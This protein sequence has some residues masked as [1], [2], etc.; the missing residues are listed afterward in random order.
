M[1]TLVTLYKF[2]ILGTTVPNGSFPDGGVTIDAQGNLYGTTVTGGAN[3]Q[4]TLYEY[5]TSSNTFTKLEDF[6]LTT[7]GDYPHNR[8]VITASGDLLG[9]TQRGGIQES[10]VPQGGFGTIYQYSPATSSFTK[11]ILLNGT[12]NPAVQPTGNIILNGYGGYDSVAA[13]GTEILTYSPTTNVTS[14]IAIPALIGVA[15]GNLTA[16]SAYKLGTNGNYLFGVADSSNGVGGAYGYGDV[17]GISESANTPNIIASFHGTDGSQPVGGLAEDAEGNLFG[18]TSAG[19]LHGFGTVF[20]IKANSHAITTLANFDGS[21]SG[22][23]PSGTLLIDQTDNLFGENSE[24]GAGGNGTVFEV[25]LTGNMQWTLKT[26]VSFP[27]DGLSGIAPFDGLSVDAQGNLYGTTAG[28]GYVGQT[29]NNP[30]GPQTGGAGTI[31]EITNS[32]FLLPT[33]P[34]PISGNAPIHAGVGEGY[35]ITSYLLSLV[36]PGT[37]GDTETIT[38]VTGHATLGGS[39]TAYYWAP[40]GAGADSFTYTVTDEHGATSTGTVTVTVGAPAAT[41]VHLNGYNDIVTWPAEWPGVSSGVAGATINGSPYGGAKITGTHDNITINAYGYGNTIVAN[42]GADTINTGQGNDS[43]TVS[44]ANADNVVTGGAGNESVTLIGSGNNTITLGGYTNRIVGGGGANTIYAG[45]GNDTVTLSD[46]VGDV[47]TASGYSNTFTLGS[48]NTT[49]QGMA[50]YSTINIRASFNASSSIDLT[51][52][53]GS[54]ALVGGVWELLSLSGGVYA[55]LNLASGLAVHLASDGH[56]GE[57]LVYGAPPTSPPPVVPVN[58]VETQGGQHVAVNTSTQ[59]VTLVG[60]G[61]T[62]TGTAGTLTISGD[63]GGSTLNI[64][65]GNN[66]LLLSGYGDTITLDVGGTGNNTVTGTQ[67]NTHISAGDGN[68]TIVA[69]GYTNVVSVGAGNSN[70]SGSAGNTIVST[71][72]TVGGG[73]GI[74]NLGGYGNT[75]SVLGGTWTITAGAGQDSVNCNA[76]TANVTLSGWN[77]VVSTITGVAS[78]TGGMG[79]DF[80]LGGFGKFS[81]ASFNAMYGDTLDLSQLTNTLPSG[82]IISGAVDGADPT[83]LDVSVTSSGPAHLVAILHGANASLASLEASRNIIP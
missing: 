69:G 22:H 75:I 82:W 4:G 23:A 34:G 63:Q 45:I 36:T 1:P 7:T 64:S 37:A 72:A 10:P 78:V 71:G 2:P 39:G 17:F 8:P 76:A 32:G 52:F 65:G 46:G 18:T 25:Q 24:G 40:S 83:G 13:L 3:N 16:E 33:P 53:N 62:V 15:Q 80:K 67:G 61:N 19:G 77:N 58:I 74:V 79:T 28:G 12:T 70:I 38:A 59:T 56:G 47:V 20:E 55:T 50:G 30:G 42:G 27:A 49:L 54:L 41:T 11:T 57:E 9:D 31:F 6:S 43:V 35:D 60:Y 14:D 5:S 29:F 21:T 68:Q 51:G 81:V 48:G 73:T 26:L 66:T 44:D